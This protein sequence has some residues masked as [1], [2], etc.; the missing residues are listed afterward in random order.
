MRKE[1]EGR[2]KRQEWG[3]R[4]ECSKKRVMKGYGLNQFVGGLGEIEIKVG[5][6][7]N[8]ANADSQQESIRGKITYH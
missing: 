1:T 2:G 5:K 6:E 3:K 7:N 4:V 8:V